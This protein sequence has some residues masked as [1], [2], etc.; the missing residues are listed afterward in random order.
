[1]L[2]LSVLLMG[3]VWTLVI[4]VLLYVGKALDRVSRSILMFLVFY[5]AVRLF[6]GPICRLGF[7]PYRE[8]FETF[9]TEYLKSRNES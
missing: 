2:C 5:A 8:Q 9:F 6:C 4:W 1:M 7:K 3:L